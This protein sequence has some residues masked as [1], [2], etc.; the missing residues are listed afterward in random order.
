MA[1]HVSNLLCFRVS[2]NQA[3]VALIPGARDNHILSSDIVTS[4]I[5]LYTCRKHLNENNVMDKIISA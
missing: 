2:L 1:D 3:E 5:Q 4:E